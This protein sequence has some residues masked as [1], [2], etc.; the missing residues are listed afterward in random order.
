MSCRSSTQLALIL[1]A[2]QTSH[3]S[4]HLCFDSFAVIVSVNYYTTHTGV[5]LQV[6]VGSHGSKVQP[7][8]RTISSDDSDAQAR[9]RS[10][11][12]AQLS[13]FLVQ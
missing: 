7:V 12:V 5:L 1:L 9:S 3:R 4:I 11:S 2:A 10:A 8:P 6:L 13:L